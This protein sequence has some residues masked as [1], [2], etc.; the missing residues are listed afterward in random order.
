MWLAR[1]L[2]IIV[3]SN[4][5]AVSFSLASRLLAAACLPVSNGEGVSALEALSP[6]TSRS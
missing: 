5:F 6:V 2:G 1:G 3:I 4:Y